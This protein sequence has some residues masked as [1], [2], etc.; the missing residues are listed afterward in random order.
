MLNIQQALPTFE[1]LEPVRI[2]R[3]EFDRFPKIQRLIFAMA[4]QAID[5][6]EA[7]DREAM[8]WLK[9]SGRE[10]LSCAGLEVDLKQIEKIG[11]NGKK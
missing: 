2:R 7:G 9:E 3:V 4:L 5:D 1:Y 11:G 10:L 8:D 6:I